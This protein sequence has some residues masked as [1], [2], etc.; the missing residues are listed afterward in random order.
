M[1]IEADVVAKAEAVDANFRLLRIRIATIAAWEVWR[2]EG[3]S[4]HSC[5]VDPGLVLCDSDV[6][7]CLP[8]SGVTRTECLVLCK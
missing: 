2:G 5:H 4:V 3:R 6:G 8:Y 7:L 1:S